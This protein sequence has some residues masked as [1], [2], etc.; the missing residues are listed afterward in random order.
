MHRFKKTQRN[1]II[2]VYNSTSVHNITV[3]AGVKK[4]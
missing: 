2:P 4:N 1:I 3:K